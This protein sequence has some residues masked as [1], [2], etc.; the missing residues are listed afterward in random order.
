MSDVLPVQ[1]VAAVPAT[2]ADP[3]LLPQSAAVSTVPAG[4]LR[5]VDPDVRATGS[6]K[7][8]LF[9][10]Y[11]FPPTGGGGVQRSAKFTKY[12]PEYGWQ[13]TVLT[14]A[15]PSVPVQDQDLQDDVNGSTTLLRARTLEPSYAMKKA[16]VDS[17]EQRSGPSI[18]TLLRRAAMQLLQPCLLYTSDAADE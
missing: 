15:N 10:S 8:L 12:L 3:G 1:S 17:G 11:A 4:A 9:I 2:A 7:R 5:P 13:A 14:A 6:K 16:L 18:R